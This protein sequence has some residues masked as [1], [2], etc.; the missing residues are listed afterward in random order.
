MFACEETCPVGMR[1]FGGN[2]ISPMRN[3]GKNARGKSFFPLDPFL[4]LCESCFLYRQVGHGAPLAGARE[5]GT[6]PILVRAQLVG[7]PSPTWDKGPQAR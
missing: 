2:P 1:L 5:R 4:W 7:T 6:K 3:G